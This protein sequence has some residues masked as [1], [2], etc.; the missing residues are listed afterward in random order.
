VSA[1]TLQSRRIFTLLAPEAWVLFWLGETG[2]MGA[3]DDSDVGY[4]IGVTTTVGSVVVFLSF[5]LSGD[6]VV[7]TIVGRPVTLDALRVIAGEAEVLGVAD[8][9][10]TPLP[11]AEAEAVTI[12]LNV[13]SAAVIMLRTIV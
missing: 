4:D 13:V 2:V 3:M 12:S 11:Y 5:P 1:T 9:V 7:T 6:M 10:T 8:E